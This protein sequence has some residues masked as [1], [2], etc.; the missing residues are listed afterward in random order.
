MSK[1]LAALPHA[2][3]RLAPYEAELVIPGSK[4]PAAFRE[5]LRKL[6]RLNIFQDQ[7][8]EILELLRLAPTA[9]WAFPGP[10]TAS[11]LP[12]VGI[13]VAE[14]KDLLPGRLSNVS[15]LADKARRMGCRPVLIP[16]CLDLLYPADPRGRA[17][18]TRALAAHFDGILGPGGA[19]VDPKIYRSRNRSSLGTNFVRDR[20]EAAFIDA[21][22]ASALFLFGV[23]R[24]HQLWNAASGGELVQDVRDEG[25]S[26]VS[27]NQRDYGLDPSEPFVVRDEA[28]RLVFEN[29]VELDPESRLETAAGT[30]SLVTNSLHHQLVKRPG[31]DLS[32]VG[33][34]FDPGTGTW[35]IEATEGWNVFTTQF[36]PELM[37]GDP[38]E[39]H[40]L[41]ALGRRAAI[42]HT[43]KAL[44][45]TGAL[46][47]LLVRLA[48]DPRLEASDLAWAKNDL[49]PRLARA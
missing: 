47:S 45:K 3:L 37:D 49:W 42:F 33:H 9:A 44:A 48:E 43:A 27:Q 10:E 34:V 12:R 35:G 39:M 46:D 25:F 36:H 5:Y 21:A 16:P 11:D 31:R 26:V 41:A 1:E 2:S 32:A 8:R 15:I 23:C 17:T 14:P 19:D 24:S 38:A 4:G 6:L 13:I 20:F 28:G 29:R 30:E 40:L 18:A 22:R 7:R